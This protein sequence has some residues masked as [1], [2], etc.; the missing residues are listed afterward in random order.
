MG[1]SSGTGGP[2]IVTGPTE[3]TSGSGGGVSGSSSGG[4]AQ[5]CVEGTPCADFFNLPASPGAG[6]PVGFGCGT[7][8]TAENPCTTNCSC[9]GPTGYLKCTEQ[10]PA[11]FDGGEGMP[12]LD[13]GDA[14]APQNGD[15]ACAIAGGGCVLPQQGAPQG[16]CGMYSAR[17]TTVSCADP[18]EIC[19]V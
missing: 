15:E 5:S 16:G 14:E 4:T 7:L 9:Y 11:G 13:S 2:G 1:S 19:C 10:C 8:P 17:V 6:G 18:N 3:S 12:A